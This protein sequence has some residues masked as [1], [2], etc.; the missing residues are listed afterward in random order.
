MYR[1]IKYTFSEDVLR[2]PAIQTTLIFQV[3]QEEMQGFFNN[4]HKYSFVRVI[5]AR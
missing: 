5:L 4:A 2:L 3:G 1:K